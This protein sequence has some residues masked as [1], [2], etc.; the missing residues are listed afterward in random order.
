M[1]HQNTLPYFGKLTLSIY[2]WCKW[3]IVA[4]I[5]VSFGS[6][7]ADAKYSVFIN[8]KIICILTDKSKNIK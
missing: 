4:V 8:C 1:S 5:S 7:S 2:L 3:V 6:A